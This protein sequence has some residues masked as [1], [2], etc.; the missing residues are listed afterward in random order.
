MTKSV[1]PRTSVVGK[2]VPEDVGRGVVVKA[3]R[4]GDAGDGVVATPDAEPS[5]ALVEEQGGAV[6]GPR[7][8][9]PLC[10][11]SQRFVEL[12]VDGNL[13]NPLSLAVDPQHALPGGAGHVVDVERTTS[14]MRAPA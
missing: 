14:A 12:R 11:P 3:G 1:P 5:A 13:P 4:R 9:G 8:V 10:E 2:R 7:P 6:A